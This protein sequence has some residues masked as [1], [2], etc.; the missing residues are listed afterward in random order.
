MEDKT[1]V[2]LKA[3]VFD[4]QTKIGELRKQMQEKLM[5]IDK[6]SKQGEKE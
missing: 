4:L 6:L 3:D 5:L 1:I 2:E